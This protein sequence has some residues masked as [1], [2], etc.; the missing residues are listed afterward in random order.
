MLARRSKLGLHRLVEG[1]AADGAADLEAHSGGCGT[2]VVDQA[3]DAGGA[4]SQGTQGDVQLAAL[5]ITDTA[6]C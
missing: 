3:S 2:A 6:D 1:R 4:G 5:G